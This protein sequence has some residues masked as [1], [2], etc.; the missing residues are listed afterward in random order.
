MFVL[1][2]AIHLAYIRG[3]SIGSGQ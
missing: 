1:D 2:S 3:E